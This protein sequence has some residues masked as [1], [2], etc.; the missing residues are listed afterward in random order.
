MPPNSFLLFA[1]ANLVALHWL[2]HFLQAFYLFTFFL[3]QFC[4]VIT[5]FFCR[6]MT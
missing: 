1:F 2:G 6:L 3:S 4:A 5:G